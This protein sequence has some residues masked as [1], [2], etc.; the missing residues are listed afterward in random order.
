MGQ[1]QGQGERVS[2]GSQVAGFV[3]MLVAVFAGAYAVGAATG[4]DG[5]PGGTA[6]GRPAATMMHPMGEG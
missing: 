4:P 6:P 5:P 3:L 2:V 1:G